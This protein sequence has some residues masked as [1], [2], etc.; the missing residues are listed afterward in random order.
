METRGHYCGVKYRVLW[1]LGGQGDPSAK[2]GVEL[3]KSL[4]CRP[5][6]ATHGP[7]ATGDWP[8]EGHFLACPGLF[9]TGNEIHPKPHSRGP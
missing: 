8:A 5:P 2:E 3:R 4:G 6:G 1:D 7:R 9:I